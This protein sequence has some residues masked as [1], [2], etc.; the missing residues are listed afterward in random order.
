M[1]SLVI[2]SLSFSNTL[3][4]SNSFYKYNRPKIGSEYCGEVRFPFIGIQN[5]N[6]KI[7]SNIKANIKLEGFVNYDDHINYH[8]D[9]KGKF[10]FILSN[11]LEKKLNKFY[12]KIT[13]ARYENDIA[14]VTVKIKPLHFSKDVQLQR[15]IC[16][17]SFLSSKH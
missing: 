7:L 1:L 3:S 11:D 15:I 17:R 9:N 14:I 8:I 4:L 10:D 13:N 5:I 6:L 16:K 12:C 2:Y